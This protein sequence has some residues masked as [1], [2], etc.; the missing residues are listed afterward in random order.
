ML[1]GQTLSFAVPTTTMSSAAQ[2]S[3][4]LPTNQ[5]IGPGWI[6][7]DTGSYSKGGREIVLVFGGCFGPHLPFRAGNAVIFAA[8]VRARL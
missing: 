4:G 5:L 1:F 2:S 3:A 7:C 8:I 6:D